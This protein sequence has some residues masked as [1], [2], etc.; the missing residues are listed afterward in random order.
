MLGR[1]ARSAVLCSVRYHRRRRPAHG[2]E[3]ARN[4]AQGLRL[5]EYRIRHRAAERP[6]DAQRELDA[7]QAVEPEVTL[8]GRVDSERVN[9]SHPRMQLGRQSAR[10]CEHAACNV[11]SGRRIPE[12]NAHNRT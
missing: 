9:A 4:V 3:G 12:N 5:G 10:H 11:G 2:H 1:A 8:N 6:L 7:P